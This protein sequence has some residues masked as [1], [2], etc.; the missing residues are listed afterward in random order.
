MQE[1]VHSFIPILF[2]F[3][4]RIRNAVHILNAIR[5]LNMQRVL[6]ITHSDNDIQTL[7]LNI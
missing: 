6:Y 2:Q 7:D 3:Y 5:D 1:V 4:T